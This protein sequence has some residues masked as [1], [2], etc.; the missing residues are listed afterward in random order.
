ML[1]EP[2]TWRPETTCSTKGISKKAWEQSSKL[3]SPEFT[4]SSRGKNNSC[5]LN[6]MKN[7]WLKKNG[8][9]F[10]KFLKWQREKYFGLPNRYMW[11]CLSTFSLP[12][13]SPL[14]KS[15]YCTKRNVTKFKIKKI[16]Y[17]ILSSRKEPFQLPRRIPLPRWG[18]KTSYRNCKTALLA[19]LP[20]GSSIVNTAERIWSNECNPYLL[21]I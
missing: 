1:I 21:S 19:Q 20:P 6:G 9:F 13:F 16:Y 7:S 14:M 18:T 12:N 15:G 11:E 5:I 17:N 2:P 10:H 8:P 3:T 4:Q